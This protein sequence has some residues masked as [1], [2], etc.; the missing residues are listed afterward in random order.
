MVA[1]WPHLV[2]IYVGL[3]AMGGGR[4]LPPPPGGTLVYGSVRL[5]RPQRSV[6]AHQSNS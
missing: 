1:Q 4:A 6:S 3:A 5:F 2:T